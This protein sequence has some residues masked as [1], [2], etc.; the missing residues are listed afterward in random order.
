MHI[1]ISHTYFSSE[2]STLFYCEMCREERN[3]SNFQI[4]V[5]F[6]SELNAHNYAQS[7]GRVIVDQSHRSDHS[8]FT[9]LFDCFC[10]VPEVSSL[11]FQVLC[12]AKFF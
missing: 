3:I 10:F 2:A 8:I 1:G 11:Y 7:S 4:D 12:G 6:L 9:A 5:A